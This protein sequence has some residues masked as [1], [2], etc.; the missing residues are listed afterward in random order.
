MFN[1]YWR[2]YP[3][4]F[5]LLQFV[6]LIFIF[7]FFFM[8]AVAPFAMFQLGVSAEDILSLSEESPRRIINAA[9]LVQFLNAAGIF[10]IPA[11][12]FAYF[13]HPRPGEYL[14]LRKPGKP[15]HWLLVVLIMLGAMPI[16]LFVAELISHLDF[17]ESVKQAQEQNDRL[18]KGLLNMTSPLHFLASFL[19]L[20][21]LPGLSEEL[22]FRGLL[23]R[24]AA[25]RSV[26]IILPLIVSAVLFTLMHSNPYG[27]LSIFL[28]GIL[29]GLLYYLTGSLWSSILA[30]VVYN[31]FQVVMIYAAK[32]NKEMQTILENNHVPVTWVVLGAVVFAGSFFWLWNVR[33][34]LPPNWAADFSPEELTEE[35]S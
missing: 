34:P 15:I 28:A 24:F 12:L 30:H 27:M 18:T 4:L 17:G 5:Q 7:S 1:R 33:T 16:F 22:F 29:L 10:L 19:V 3:W 32:G 26:S 31:G 20:A 35:A 8:G 13:T 2:T 21:I 14:G 23:M 9:L 11:L 6:I 25:K